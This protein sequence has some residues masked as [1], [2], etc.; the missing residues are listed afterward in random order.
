MGYT[1]DLLAEIRL[2]ALEGLLTVAGAAIDPGEE[3]AW[4]KIELLR[5]IADIN[6][7]ILERMNVE[8]YSPLDKSCDEFVARCLADDAPCECAEEA[9]EAF[10]RELKERK[11]EAKATAAAHMSPCQFARAYGEPPVVF[12]YTFMES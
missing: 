12:A 1:E 2:A 3:K 4:D 8:W 7:T 6:I 11:A 10:V 9:A 5:S